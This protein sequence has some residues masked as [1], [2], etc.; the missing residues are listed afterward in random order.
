MI[1]LCVNRPYDRTGC[2][3][4]EE[5]CSPNEPYPGPPTLV[6]R[7]RCA[8]Y[9][10]GMSESERRSRLVA[11]WAWMLLIAVTG[12]A[13]FAVTSVTVGVCADSVHP[14]RSYCESGPM[15]GAAGVW[16]AWIGWATLTGF[17]LWRL[18]RWR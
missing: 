12:I 1:R 4:R 8:R 10:A 5:G 15:I 3:V 17:C 9:S 14:W 11:P 16:I 18:S 2:R 6:A 7:A 13:V